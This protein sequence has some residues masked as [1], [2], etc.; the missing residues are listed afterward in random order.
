VQ[1]VARG[2]LLADE[3]GGVGERYILG[4]RNY[5]FDRLFADLARLSG[6]E[7]PALRLPAQAAVRLAQSMEAASLGRPPLSVPEVKLAGQWWTYSNAKAKRELGWQPS[8]HEET[9]EATIEWYREREG[10]RIKRARRSQP[11]QYKVAGAALGAA[12]RFIP[13]VAA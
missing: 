4:N 1:D 2:Q 7:P 11:L 8:P 3:R 9:L 12:R 10:E 6:V 5:T 13:G